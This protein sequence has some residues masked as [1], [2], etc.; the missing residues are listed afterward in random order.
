M[1]I[2]T[3]NVNSLRV[4][5]SHLLNWLAENQP[6]IVALQET[7]V[8]DDK[9][10]QAEIAAAGYQVV[11]TGQKTFNGVTILSRIPAA[12]VVLEVPDLSDTQKRF[13]AA[14]IGD[15]R[16]INLY[17]PNGESLASEKFQ[18]KMAWLEQVKKYIAAQLQ[19]HPNLII[20]G[21]FN[22]APAAADVYAPDLWEGRVLCSEPERDMFQK[23]L[24]LGVK[25]T[26]RLLHQEA[27]HYSWW[28]YRAG[29]FWRN[30][31]LRIDHILA[32]ESLS[33]RCSHCI[34]DKKP[35]KLPQPSDHTPVMGIFA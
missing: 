8:T 27:G 25:D 14:T 28:D 7:K 9:F 11:F 24:A 23:I 34:I 16:I 2:A 17:V 13:L 10:P 26:F 12:D 32:S 20:L 21:D 6:D 35:R 22:I 31:G 19:Q 3:W 5:L 33:Q 15:I 30:N 4:R 1:K 29:S 18:Y